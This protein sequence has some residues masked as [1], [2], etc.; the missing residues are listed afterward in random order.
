MTTLA[1]GMTFHRIYEPSI[2]EHAASLATL[3]R[4]HSITRS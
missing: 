1:D 2:S 4:W 3:E